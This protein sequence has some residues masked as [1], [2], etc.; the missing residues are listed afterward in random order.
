MTLQRR[1]GRRSD[2]DCLTVRRPAFRPDPN[3]RRP[4]ALPLILTGFGIGTAVIAIAL[5]VS[6][7]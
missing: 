7:R 4:S 5:L 3:T 2:P 1:D 6:L